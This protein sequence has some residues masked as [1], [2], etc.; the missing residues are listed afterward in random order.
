MT[1]LQYADDTLIF[2]DA[3]IGQLR[4]LRVILVLFEGMTGL[5]INWGKSLL[6]PINEVTNMDQLA[7]VLGGIVGAMPATYL[8]MP[9]GAKSKSNEIW[10]S[11]VESVKKG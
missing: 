3:E 1:H 8:G 4:Y 7:A 6:Y 11:V 2:C 9:L 5:H 10:N